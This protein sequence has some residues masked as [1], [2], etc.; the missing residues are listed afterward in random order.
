[1]NMR[2]EHD[3]YIFL[4]QL[5]QEELFLYVSV[6]LPALWN[7]R[8]QMSVVL[9]RADTCA[10]VSIN[11]QVQSLRELLQDAGS[12]N[13]LQDVISAV[14]KSAGLTTVADAASLLRH[15][16]SERPGRWVPQ[17]RCCFR[18]GGRRPQSPSA[19]GAWTL[20]VSIHRG[21]RKHLDT[22]ASLNKPGA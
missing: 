22:K 14:T 4:K 9:R 3:S 15:P 2:T 20:L 19:K 6:M 18:E 16:P 8:L 5:L 12:T 1:M 11:L 10:L 17:P 21:W 7:L 13:D